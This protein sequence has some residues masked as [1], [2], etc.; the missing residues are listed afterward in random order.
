MLHY[1]NK[2]PEP[3]W[4]AVVTDICRASFCLELAWNYYPSCVQL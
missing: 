4:K 2:K 3:N 1:T